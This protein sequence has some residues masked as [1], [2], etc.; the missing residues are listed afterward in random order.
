MDLLDAM[1]VEKTNHKLLGYPNI[2]QGEMQLECQLASNGIYIGD[3]T[4]YNNPMIPSLKNGAMNWR[5][6]LQ[7]DSDDRTG[8]MWGD[9][10]R[11]YFWILKQ[12]LKNCNFDN[13]WMILQCY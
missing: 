11:L 10:G 6:L 3:S 2:I 7:I 1:N 5:L 8:M 9:A 4:G 13:V 12:D